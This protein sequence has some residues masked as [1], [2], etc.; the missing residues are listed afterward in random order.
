MQLI[1]AVSKGF[2]LMTVAWEYFQEA[3]FPIE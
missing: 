1:S 2:L 3:I